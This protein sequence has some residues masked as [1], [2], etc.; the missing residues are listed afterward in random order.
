MLTNIKVA[1][2]VK[3]N[4]Q[5][6]GIFIAAALLVFN[7]TSIEVSA[8]DYYCLRDAAYDRPRDIHRLCVIGKGKDPEA[9]EIHQRLAG[10]LEKSG[11]DLNLNLSLIDVE[12]PKINWHDYGLPSTPPPPFPAT[13]LVEHKTIENKS[14]F[15]EF[16]LP[17]P[18]AAD[19]ERMKTSPV[20]EVIRREVGKHIAVLLYSRGTDQNTGQGRKVLEAVVKNWADKEQVG[21]TVI[22][23]NRADERERL[24]LPFVGLKPTGPDWVSVIFGRGKFMLPLEGEEITEEILNEHIELLMGECT[25]LQSPMTLGIDILSTWNE[26]DEKAVIPL[27]EADNNTEAAV[28]TSRPADIVD[29]PIGRRAYSR[30]IWTLAVIAI[31]VCLA[32]MVLIRQRNR[33]IS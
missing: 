19:L 1:A 13:I 4:W 25:C 18:K 26:A 10:W 7:L 20:R 15:I 31:I 30:T 17:E 21:L 12:D 28:A 2:P 9:R 33:S 22:E 23:I 27:L 6:G 5:A 29:S 16:W 3:N 14:W 11:K 24:F 8:C 32:T